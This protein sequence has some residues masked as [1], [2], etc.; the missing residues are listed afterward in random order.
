[1]IFW[2]YEHLSAQELRLGRNRR[3]M[4][5]PLDMRRIE[6]RANFHTIVIHSHSNTER[7]REVVKR[8]QSQGFALRYRLSPPRLSGQEKGGRF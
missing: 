1:M 6:E 7:A 5:R 2:S 4:V 3:P 8:M